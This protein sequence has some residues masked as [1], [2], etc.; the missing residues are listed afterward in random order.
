MP[1]WRAAAASNDFSGGGEGS[2]ASVEHSLI[3]MAASNMHR[4][5]LLEA[6]AAWANAARDPHA[7]PLKVR[8]LIIL[9]PLCLPPF[10]CF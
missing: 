2:G 1:P 6:V 5:E 9:A 4:A 10:F 7:P 3:V 8:T